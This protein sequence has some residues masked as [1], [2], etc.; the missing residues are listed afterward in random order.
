MP[1]FVWWYENINVLFFVNF[2]NNKK[3]ISLLLVVVV[4]VV[5]DRGAVDLIKKVDNNWLDGATL[6]SDAEV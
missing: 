5:V 6:P 2:A 1:V 4:A 3:I